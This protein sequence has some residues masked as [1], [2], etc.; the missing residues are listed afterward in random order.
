M[1]DKKIEEAKSSFDVNAEVADPID[2][3]STKRPA[4]KEGGADPAKALTKAQMISGITHAVYKQSHP[5][6]TQLYREFFKLQG[7]NVSAEANR[8]TIRA[9]GLKEDVDSLFE[10]QE[11]SEDFKN[12]A[13]TIFESAVNAAIIAETAALEEEFEERLTEEVEA[14]M[15]RLTES[16][17]KYL[18]SVA[19]KWLE[20]NRVAV[21]SSLRSEI[22]E[23]FLTGM[24]NLFTEHYID[25]P[26]EK[27]DVVEQLASEVQNLTARL[28]ESEHRQIEQQNMIE[29]HQRK[30]IV[31]SLAE[32][33]AET[34]VETL[35]TLSED[36]SFES[37]EA[38]GNAVRKLAESVTQK[39]APVD[40]STQL[41]EEVELDES[42]KSVTIDPVVAAALAVGSRHRG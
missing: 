6:L 18:E 37:P 29:Q 15:G 22:T 32:G 3:G 36:L 31:A 30:A 40:A 41:N 39:K 21:A 8:A 10:G 17:D 23:S 5:E 14:I 2:A 35:H 1:T 28:N 38:F 16:L 13:S 26:E 7:T 12:N 33:L 9:G 11:L 25:V 4:D 42:A 19:T 34:Q 27:V 20:E 24:K